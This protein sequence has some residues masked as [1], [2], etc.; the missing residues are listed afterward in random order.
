MNIRLQLM[1][2]DGSTCL[3]TILNLAWCL[4]CTSWRGHYRH[5]H[6]PEVQISTGP[7]LTTDH[8]ILYIALAG[9]TTCPFI[10]ASS[11]AF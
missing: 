9:Q 11:L 8:C 1:K 2:A 5:D 10:V 6:N 3:L 4:L 7:G